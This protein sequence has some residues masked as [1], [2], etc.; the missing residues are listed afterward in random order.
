MK[1]KGELDPEL[2]INLCNKA[3]LAFLQRHLGKLPRAHTHTRPDGLPLRQVWTEA[4]TS[5]TR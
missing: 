1:L 2:A 3:T 4:L 5:G